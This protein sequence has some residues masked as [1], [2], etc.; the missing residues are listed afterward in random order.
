MTPQ[1]YLSF[2]ERMTFDFR[3]KKMGLMPGKTPEYFFDILIEL[4]AIHSEKIINA[5]RDCLVSGETRRTACERYGAS[6]SYFSVALGRLFR[7][8]QL[9]S[10]LA[11]YYCN[12]GRFA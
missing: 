5:L 8:S 1:N 11:P 3:A 2:S 12:D 7:V 10:Q 9:V 6:I 4:S